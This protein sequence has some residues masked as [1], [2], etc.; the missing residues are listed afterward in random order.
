MPDP[1]RRSWPRAA[2]ADL[3]RLLASSIDGELLKTLLAFLNKD[4]HT[5]IKP[6][7]NGAQ[8]K[9]ACTGK[10]P[11][12]SLAADHRLLMQAI[13]A[14]AEADYRRAAIDAGTATERA[15]AWAIS[16]ELRIRG[17]NAEYIEQTILSCNGLD[18]LFRQY[19]S[20]GRDLPVSIGKMRNR[21]A[22]VRN[23][24]A[25]AG[26]IPS[27]EEAARA[28]ELAHDLVKAVHP[29]L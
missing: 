3:E 6:P 19:S 20:F 10:A 27:A 18:G 17:L 9:P 15:L 7:P 24:A 14:L 13:M 16:G 28:V 1:A 25:H 21:L 11:E 8:F 29:F 4:Y 23:E 22:H 2:H 12:T 26:R 5:L